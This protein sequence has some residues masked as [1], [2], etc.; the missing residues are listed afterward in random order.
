[1][2]SVIGDFGKLLANDLYDT[3]PV[4]RFVLEQDYQLFSVLK[5]DLFQCCPDDV[6]SFTFL[7]Y[8]F[9]QIDSPFSYRRWNTGLPLRATSKIFESGY[10][11]Y[12]VL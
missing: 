4:D 3:V 8:I 5:L 12:A 11:K 9:L 6:S 2:L 10:T 1:M 7:I